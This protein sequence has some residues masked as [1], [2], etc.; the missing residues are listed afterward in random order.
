MGITTPRNDTPYEHLA[1]AYRYDPESGDFYRKRKDGTEKRISNRKGNGYTIV[2]LNYRSYLASRVAILLTTGKWPD[3]YVDHING[4]RN[5]NR[6]ENL[7]VVSGSG[8]QQNKSLSKSNSCGF[9][10]VWKREGRSKPYSAMITINRKRIFVGDFHTPE[11]AHAAYLKK[12]EEIHPQY[13][14]DRNLNLYH[15]PLVSP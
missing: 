2:N 3:G 10:G 5:D 4:I 11:E 12:K 14:P 1:E 8:N 7:R 9:L 6:L 13:N 15:A